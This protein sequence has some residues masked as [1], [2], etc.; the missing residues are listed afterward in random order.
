MSVSSSTWHAAFAVGV[1]VMVALGAI[2]ALDGSPQGAVAL[3]AG[4]AL[5]AG[6][7]W[8]GPPQR[9][10]LIGL[11]FLTAPYDISKAII[12]PVDRFYSPGL[13]VTV[14]QAILLFLTAVWGVERIFVQR[15]RLPCT[16]LD[17]LAFGFLGLVWIGALRSSMDPLIY[18]SA[19]SYSLCVLGFYVVSHAV[20]SRQDVRLLLA[21]VI[22][23]FGL[24]AV[25]VAAQIETHAPLP[26]PGAKV[27]TTADIEQGLPFRPA[28]GFE[29]PNSLADYLSLLIP[30][31]LAVFLLGRRRMPARARAIAGLVAA[32][33]G[34][35]L[36]L[37][38][39]R[40]G[41]A[42]CLLGSLFVA[43]VFWRTRLIDSGYLLAF[44]GA[45]LACLLAAVLIFPQIVL[46]VT[47][48]DSR[49]TESRAVLSDQ[50]MTII[51]ANP[52]LGVGFG[53]YNRAA[54]EYMPPAFALISEDYQIQL[55]KLVVHNHY[56][57][58]AAELGIPAMLYW[59]YLMLR[60]VRQA[61]PLSKWRDPGRFALA[62]G[63]SGALAS[64]MLFLTSDNYYTDLRVYLLWLTAGL[65]QSL[66]LQAARDA[67]A[68][69]QVK[70]P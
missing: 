3:V 62:V 34:T 56:L 33:A 42:A 49:S 45:A 60:F 35:L 14:S 63:L 61:W 2:T 50:A 10:H 51:K 47:E 7:L 21:M 9:H 4:L 64:Q 1:S 32:V 11:L 18:G 41:W 59:I 24:Q 16:R 46:R 69:D 67:T 17:L 25:Y 57:L 36:L 44:A 13:Y 6:M 55:R 29:H 38:L 66:T 58:L 8:F 52:L 26:L 31:A 43:A 30:P 5:L 53:G 65:L 19:I 40:G 70:T 15:L 28:G 23:G 48:S 27:G 68:D 39:S 37:T 12:A 20:Q 54:F 22:L